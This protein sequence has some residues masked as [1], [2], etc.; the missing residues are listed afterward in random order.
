M[1][2]LKS[3]LFI[4]VEGSE[5]VGKS[6]CIA[7]IKNW[8]QTNGLPNIATREPGG[9]PFAEAIR[10]LLLTP[11][12]EPVADI[13]ELLLMFAARAQ[14]IEQVIKPAMAE[15]KVVVCD[16]FTDATY[17]YQGGG[18]GGDVLQISQLEQLVQGSLRPHATLLLDMSVA[19]ALQRAAKRGALD[20]IESQTIDFFERVRQAYLE[21]AR[22]YPEQFYLIDA[23]QPLEQVQQQVEQ[24]LAKVVKQ[25]A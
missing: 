12:Q 5:G 22:Q 20:R 18:R 8:L 6:T 14:H 7:F 4:T 11:Q 23:S 1:S 19:D 17:A 25:H 3:G 10:N 21:R 2:K 24:V 13:T 9:T 15:Q 16:R